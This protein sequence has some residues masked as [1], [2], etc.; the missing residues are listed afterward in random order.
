RACERAEAVALAEVGRP[1]LGGTKLSARTENVHVATRAIAARVVEP[2]GRVVVAVPHRDPRVRN[3]DARV[4]AGVAEWRE[5]GRT[6]IV[7][8][9]IE[10]GGADAR[11]R[12]QEARVGIEIAPRECDGAIA[13]RDALAVDAALRLAVEP[14][15]SGR[16]VVHESRGG[17][18]RET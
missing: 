8:D 18:A 15:H 10:D 11:F 16:F 14:P 2:A 7:R 13:R 5:I 4:R 3:E 12:V 9:G 17:A 6:E 1:R